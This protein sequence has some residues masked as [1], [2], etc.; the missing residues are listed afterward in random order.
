MY[1]CPLLL[2]WGVF[3]H[4]LKMPPAQSCTPPCHRKVAAGAH[5]GGGP[6]L[7]G[8]GDY[9]GLTGDP[10]LLSIPGTHAI[11]LF[12]YQKS[13]ANTNNS[14]I[15]S[16]TMHLNLNCMKRQPKLK[17]S[18]FRFKRCKTIFDSILFNAPKWGSPVSGR[19]RRLLPLQLYHHDR[20]HHQQLQS[21]QVAAA[22]K[23]NKL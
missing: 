17:R 23:L 20:S 9:V 18:F 8:G 2:W 13:R 7:C 10:P 1:S 19:V 16:A 12:C 5:L 11:L 4:T 3:T 21:Q 14:C 22:L 6:A 15:S